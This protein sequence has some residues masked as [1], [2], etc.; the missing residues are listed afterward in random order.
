MTMVTGSAPVAPVISINAV[1][2]E[3]PESGSTSS[4]TAAVAAVASEVASSSPKAAAESERNLSV[5]RFFL[6]GLRPVRPSSRR[7]NPAEWLASGCRQP[8]P[9]AHGQRITL[10]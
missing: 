7:S 2:P 3:G 8:P 9:L 1:V 5:T 6:S 4:V 10:R